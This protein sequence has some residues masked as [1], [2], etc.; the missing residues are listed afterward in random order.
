MLN[1]EL[2]K[3]LMRQTEDEFKRPVYQAVGHTRWT[4]EDFQK[5]FPDLTEE[6]FLHDMGALFD[7]GYVSRHPHPRLGDG[8][9]GTPEGAFY[10]TEKYLKGE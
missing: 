1:D 8:F 9:D 3:A 10:L 5:K 2:L 7:V 6:R 4:K